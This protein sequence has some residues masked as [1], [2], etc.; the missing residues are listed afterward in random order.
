MC[1][2]VSRMLRSGGTVLIVGPAGMGKSTLAAQ[3]VGTLRSIT[4]QALPALADLDYRPLAHALGRP[5]AATVD[6]HV[7]SGVRRLGCHTRRQ[8]AARVRGTA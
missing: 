4:G 6:S 7:A 3:A 5:Q 1:I 8:A 2:G